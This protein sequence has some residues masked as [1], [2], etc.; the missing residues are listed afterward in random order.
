MNATTPKIRRLPDWRSRLIDYLADAARS[1][2]EEGQYDCALFFAGGVQAMT[3]VDHAEAYRGRYSTTK[4][5]L[6]ILRKDGF[7]DHIAL[8]AHYLPEKPVAFAAEGDGAVIPTPDGPALGIVQGEGVYV[9]SPD[10]MAIVPLVTA[11][12]A[13]GV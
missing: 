9:L 6:R 11:T 2:F 5:G 4:G 1:P 3:G 13:F 7:D 8:A 12:R 10:R